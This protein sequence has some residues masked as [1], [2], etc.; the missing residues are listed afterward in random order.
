MCNL[1]IQWYQS[2]PVLFLEPRFFFSRRSPAA[3]QENLTTERLD[4]IERHLQNLESKADGFEKLGL[5]DGQ[6][7]RILF[8]GFLKLGTLKSQGFWY[9]MNH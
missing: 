2:V 9:A 6:L 8:E 5:V 3:D 1:E 7:V 4:Q